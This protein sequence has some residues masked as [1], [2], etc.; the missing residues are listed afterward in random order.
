MDK[1]KG[2][3]NMKRILRYIVVAVLA[4]CLTQA[5]VF[6]EAPVEV[7]LDGETIA[8]TDAQPQIVNDRT[9]LPLRAVFEAMGAEVGYDNGVVSAT[10]GD[11]SVSMTI[12]S[13]QALVTKNGVTTELAMDVA[14]YI[15]PALGRTYVPVRFAAQALGASVGWDNAERTVVIVDTEKQLSAAL[16]G[17]T[18]TYLEKLAAYSAQFTEGTWSSDVAVKGS[19]ELNMGT[20][21]MPLKFSAP[22]AAEAKGVTVDSSKMEVTEKLTMDL[23]SLSS[24]VAASVS[25]AETD[26]AEAAQVEAMVKA[27]SENGITIAMRGDLSAGKLYMNIDA[28]ALGDMAQDAAGLALDKDAWYVMDLDAM[29]GDTGIDF[30]ELMQQ[31]KNIDFKELIGGMLAEVDVNSAANGYA[32]FDAA[33]KMMVNALSDDGFTKNGNVFST[34]FAQNL[35]G[36]ALKLKLSLTMQNDAVVAYGVDMTMTGEERGMGELSVGVKMAVDAQNK[37]TGSM[38]MDLAGMIKGSFD[39]TGGYTKGGTAPNTEPPAGAKILDLMQTLSNTETNS[40]R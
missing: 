24:L 27:L 12:G 31:T 33:L 16:E 25:G 32:E 26:A 40:L 37:L 13:T 3:I 34:S 28:S 17:K 7:Q 6:A 5:A 36:M 29:T 15:D 18:F 8:F 19:V 20:A 4:L 22:V 23:S 39:L 21:D 1:A 30:A 9:F 38:T 35:E 2:E 10:R 11:T 14:P